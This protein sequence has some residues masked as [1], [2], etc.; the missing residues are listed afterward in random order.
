MPSQAAEGKEGR[1]PDGNGG[2]E[3]GGNGGGSAE[4]WMPLRVRAWI[5][6]GLAGRQERGRQADG[7]IDR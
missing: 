2:E 5:L 4:E 6:A 3:R 7:Q 1:G